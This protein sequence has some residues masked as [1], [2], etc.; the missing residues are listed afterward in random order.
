L[1][2][3]QMRALELGRYMIRATGNGATAL[4][5]ERGRITDRIPQF[6]RA[7]LTGSVQPFEGLTPYARFGSWPILGFCCLVLGTVLV[8]GARTRGS[9][10]KG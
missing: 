7:V 8:G 2:M 3:A 4:I 9:D 5:D 6:E 10:P 1:Q